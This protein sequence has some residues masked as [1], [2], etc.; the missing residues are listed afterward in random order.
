MYRFSGLPV[1]VL[2]S[3]TGLTA[4]VDYLPA[5]AVGEAQ[6]NDRYNP[7]GALDDGG[8]LSDVTGLVAWV[9]YIPVYASVLTTPWSTDGYVPYDELAESA[10]LLE[11]GDITLLESGSYLLL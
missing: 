4:W 2:P 11:S 8:V 5:K 7:T 6:D 10:L 9:D 3:V 1:Y